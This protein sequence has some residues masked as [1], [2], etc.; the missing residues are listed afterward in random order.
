M[1]GWLWRLIVGHFRMLPPHQ[2]RWEVLSTH[3]TT[4]NDSDVIGERYILKCV[5][6]GDLKQH[7]FF[8]H[9]QYE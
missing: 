3:Q 1:L 5:D 8:V 4:K 2:H 9:K 7:R 6:C